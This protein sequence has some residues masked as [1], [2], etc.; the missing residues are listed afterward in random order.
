MWWEEDFHWSLFSR[1]ADEILFPVLS[2]GANG[3]CNIQIEWIVTS[4]L[5]D[6]GDQQ[7]W[8]KWNNFNISYITGDKRRYL[9]NGEGF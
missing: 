4:T 2:W 3:W 7:Q 9:E 8:A 1:Q 5:L 6:V